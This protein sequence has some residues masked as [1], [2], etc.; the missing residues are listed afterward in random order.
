M[1]MQA[2]LGVAFAQGTLKDYQRAESFLPQNVAKL[3]VDGSVSPNWIGESGRFWYLK[4]L[5]PDKEFLVV[6]SAAGAQRAA[7]D[8]EKLAAAL[9][10]AAGK[11]YKGRSLPFDRFEFSEDEKSI[12][13][14]AEGTRWSCDLS[15]NRCES[16]GRAAEE[17]VFRGGGRRGP[18]GDFGNRATSPDGQF[19]AFVRDNNLY[20][21]A[22]ATGQE[23][24][25]TT[26]GE[27]LFPYAIGWPNLTDLVREAT[28]ERDEPPGPIV[29]WSPDS[30]KIASFRLDL[31]SAPEV[32][33]LQISPPN[34]L[35]PIG[36]TYA[37]ALPVSP[38][39]PTARPII[40]DIVKR[41]RI[42]VD[43]KPQQIFYGGGPRFQ[44]FKDGSGIHFREIERGYQRIGLLAADAATGKVRTLIDERS[45]SYVESGSFWTELVND[46][47]EIIISSERDGWNHLYLYNG[48]T[49]QLKNQITKG[50][51]VV[52]GIEYVDEKNR[53]IFFLANGREA[54]EDPYFR[55]LYRIGFDGNGLVNLTPENADHTVTLSPD[56]K[57]LVDTYSRVD[58]PPVS[59]LRSAADG[60]VKMKLMESD[61][62]KL[63]ATGWRAP[64]RFQAKARDGKTDI[65][66]VLWRPTNLDESKKYPIV[67]Y[68]YTGPHS[69]FAPTSFNTR[70][71]CQSLVEL[72]FLCLQVDGM[73]TNHRGK[74][75]HL[76]SYKNLGDGGIDDHIAAMKQLASKYSY[77]DLTRVGVFGHSAGGYDSTHAMLTHPEFYKAAVSSAGNHDHRLD[78]VGW[79]EQWMG[80]P[81]GKHYVEQSNITM[82]PKL[83]GKLLLAV[84]DV[85]ENV[86]PI[87]TLKVATALVEANKDFDFFIVPNAPH[88]FGSNPYFVR[89][90]W[91]HFVRHLLGVTP[92]DNYT[93]KMGDG[94]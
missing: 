17:P 10:A 62:T 85:D 27:D 65:Y 12:R 81:A 91:D 70:H 48:K 84:G 35:L 87:S 28:S 59:V 26:D 77:M 6:D 22:V 75:F 44:W 34:R 16:R 42:D 89:R 32:S 40:F 25:L 47:E 66:G 56:Q 9:S 73:G 86:P 61:I 21:R 58:T 52:R 8:H 1:V 88:G 68:I 80:Y 82:A 54:G 13:F 39:L 90:R 53:Q 20:V 2:F 41:E 15:G 71:L 30:T 46:G 94:T 78:K 29:S 36:Y 23:I 69:S 24:Q 60:S 45:D 49:G 3:V 92:P 93:I 76:V 74:A 83:Q 67:E 55:H 31:R 33:A 57:V 11:T 19:E 72:G 37:Y 63:K 51:W 38:Q 43:V 5:Q 14:N 4:E 64:E 50:E 7:F 79:V 18:R